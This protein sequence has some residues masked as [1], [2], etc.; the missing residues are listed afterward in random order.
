VTLLQVF[1][2]L[3]YT[4]LSLHTEIRTCLKGGRG[5]EFNQKEGWGHATVH[6]A[7][8]KI[9]TWLNGSPVYLLW[10]TSTAKFL[11]RSIILDDDILLRCLY[12]SL[13]SQWVDIRKLGRES[14]VSGDLQMINFLSGSPTSM[15]FKYVCSNTVAQQNNSKYSLLLLFILESLKS[16]KLWFHYWPNLASLDRKENP[17]ISIY[18]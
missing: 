16:I 12:S 15:F 8:S 9:P 5:G 6:K 11:Y 7:G 18:I 4:P 17:R 10:S 1:I 14:L 2:C 3:S 13:Y